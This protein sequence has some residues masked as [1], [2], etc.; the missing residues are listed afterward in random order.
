[1]KVLV[2]GGA[3]F[4]GSHLSRELIARG[5]KVIVLDNCSTGELANLQWAN[6]RNDLQF[7]QGDIR[8]AALLAKIIPGCDWVFHH[9]AVASVPLSIEQP[10][11]TNQ[12]NLDATLSL[13]ALSRTHGV[14]RFIFASS[15]AIYGELNE[16]ARESLPVN[17]LTPYALQKY[18][19]ERYCQIFTQ[20]HGLQTVALRYFNVFGPNQNAAS[21]YSGVIALFCRKALDGSSPTIYGDGQQRRDFV[22]VDN[23]VAANMLAAESSTAPGKVFNIGMGSSITLLDLLKELEI[24]TGHKISPTFAPTREGDI[25]FSESDISRARAELGFNPKIG[26]QEGL[27]RTLEFYRPTKA[28][29]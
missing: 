22:Y 12:Q 28:C 14:R 20:F 25:H 26:W 19:A 11:E 1:M 13:L 9:A 10:E 27:K 2:T 5:A 7:V 4:I 23:V 3:G 24:L 16:P 6:G 18:A 8:D 21:P 15:S 29:C 17:P